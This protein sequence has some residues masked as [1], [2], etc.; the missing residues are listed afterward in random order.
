MESF[1]FSVIIPH[2]NI[3][4]LLQ[5]CLDSIP[6]RNDIQIIVVDDNSDENKVDFCDFPGLNDNHVEVYFT[7]EGK[8]AGY[9][10][11][12]GLTHA[13]GKWLLFADADDFFTENAFDLFF[14]QQDSPHDI[15]YFKVTNCYS[16][17][18]KLARLYDYW[19]SLI[20][21]Y[22]CK[23]KDSENNLRY[24]HSVPWGKMIKTEFVKEENIRF[25][26]VMAFNDVMF[27]LKTGFKACSIGIVDHVLYCVT[28]RR[29]SIQHTKSYEQLLSSY[30]VILRM[31][32]FFRKNGKHRYQVSTLRFFYFATKYGIVPF[33]YFIKLSILYKN[34]IFI[35][36]CSFK[37]IK[38]F[39][40]LR[41]YEKTNKKYFVTDGH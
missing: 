40:K 12:I 37:W 35:G 2:K 7:K 11:N 24:Y 17:T 19:N 5:R 36:I 41:K 33:L 27:S 22:L 3:P 16:D 10:R 23:K 30:L 6:R 26:E 8:G 4:D 14:A 29:G 13:K 39:F 32:E 31:N 28:V 18:Y 1:V 25:D 9:A 15:I 34:N 38:G 21:K 20:E